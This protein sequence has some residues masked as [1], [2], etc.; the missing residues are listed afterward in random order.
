M[1]P[2]LRWLS[3]HA[4]LLAASAILL[5]VVAALLS[6]FFASTTTLGAHDW[7]QMEGNR[8]FVVKSLRAFGQFPFWDPYSCGGFSAWGGAESDTT[9]VSPF[10]PVYLALPL[11]TAVRVEVTVLVVLMVV[12]L[13]FF[14][15]HYVEDPLALA[16]V[17]LVGGLNSRG[18]L[19]AAL[20]HTWHLYYAGMPWV[21]G[22]FDR[23]MDEARPQRR[24]LWLAVGAII[25]ALMIYGGGIYPVPHTALCL[26]CIGAYRA[27]AA[28]SWRPLVTA[29]GLLAW[30]AMFAAPKLFAIQ[31]VMSRFPRHAPSTEFVPPLVWIQ[32]FVS[33][34]GQ[35]P[36]LHAPGLPYLWHEF[37]QY[38]GFV[39]LGVL[40]WGNRARLPAD[41]RREAVR[42]V[43]YFMMMLALGYIGPW[44]LL[45]LIPPFSSQRVPS[46]FTYPGFILISIVAGC[47][48]ESALPGWKERWGSRK[49]EAVRWS[50]FVICAAMIAR[51][52]RLCTLPWFGLEVPA[53]A[54]R[55]APFVQYR[56]TPPEYVYAP[57]DQMSSKASNGATGLLR[58][59]ANVGSIKCSEFAGLNHDVASRADGRPPL[60]G[61]RGIGDPLYRGE[62]WVEPAAGAAGVDLVRWTPNLVVLKTHDTE[63][64]DVVVLNQNWA[65][66]WTA[67]G[68]PALNHDEVNAY[69]V[70]SPDET[71]TFRYRPRTL[72]AGLV[73]LLLALMLIPV[74]ALLAR[75]HRVD[76]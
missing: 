73:V 3:S 31:E 48:I 11:A 21:L 4:A 67:N 58:L 2:L 10:L 74:A 36:D 26:V 38:V 59:E 68:V 35:F 50:V 61:A 7:D 37:G 39:P 5:G 19:Q 51:E 56:E 27:G 64:G 33:S 43:G 63:T 18:A 62:F 46:R 49:V 15:R 54:E 41:P 6:G 14:A 40:V 70:T 1:R 66:G 45:H 52:D 20:G 76:R 13:W 29:V 47:A 8:Y 57:N 32:M 75:R 34:A 24:T 16:F 65:A 72:T 25:F 23:A 30:G 69:R 28:R 60:L 53:Q 44:G 12:G 22:A 42:I 71:V 55:E 9:V 17:C